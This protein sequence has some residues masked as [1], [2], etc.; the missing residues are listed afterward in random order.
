[1]PYNHKEAF[2][3]MKYQTKDTFLTETLWNSRDGVTPFII[4]S[5]D[6]REMSHIDWARDRCQPD[7][8]PPKGMRVFVDATEDLVR[9]RLNAYVE[10][11]FAEHDGGYWKTREEAYSAL[12]PGWLKDGAPWIITA[13]DDNELSRPK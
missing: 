4:S 1:M 6:G 11:I 7:F 2:C 12:L 9:D 10:K 13:G 8:H 3:L 5:T